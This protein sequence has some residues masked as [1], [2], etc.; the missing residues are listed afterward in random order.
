MYLKFSN[1]IMCFNV[2]SVQFSFVAEKKVLIS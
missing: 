1:F 2:T